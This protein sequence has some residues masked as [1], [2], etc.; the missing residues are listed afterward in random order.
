MIEAV[1]NAGYLINSCTVGLGSSD[2]NA[3][4]G[5]ENASG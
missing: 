2:D 1:R 5:I 4:D 3:Q